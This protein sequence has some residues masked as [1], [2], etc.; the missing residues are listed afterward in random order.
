MLHISGWNTTS[1][2][3]SWKVTFASNPDYTVGQQNYKQT[4]SCQNAHLCMLCCCLKIWPC[5]LKSVQLV[6]SRSASMS[7]FKTPLKSWFP[8][9]FCLLLYVRNS[10]QNYHQTKSRQNAHL[11]LQ[12]CRLNVWPRAIRSLLLFIFGVLQ[13]P[14]TLL[15]TCLLMLLPEKKTVQN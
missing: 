5:T 9:C 13:R 7:W 4:R 14:L 8:E 6:T 11:C 12:C 15:Y 2:L 1:K 3:I 10:Q